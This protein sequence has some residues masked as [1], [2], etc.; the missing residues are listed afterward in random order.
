MCAQRARFGGSHEINI[1]ED[2][3]IG[4]KGSGGPGRSY[5]LPLMMT[6]E[7]QLAHDRYKVAVES[8]EDFKTGLILLRT[9]MVVRN[10]LTAKDLEAMTKRRGK[11]G[12]PLV[13]D[14]EIDYY[15]EH[16]WILDFRK[17]H[18]DEQKQQIKQS[19]EELL[20]SQLQDVAAQWPP[21]KEKTRDYWMKVAKE[22]PELE[23]SQK[24]IELARLTT[25][26]D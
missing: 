16:G 11:D 21:I 3:T 19:E 20:N 15:V 6:K 8:P 14:E 18:Q 24:I 4:G 10:V 22:H 5:R 7:M 9:G 17:E 12:D 23:A 25:T 2:N 26:T 13:M 1:K